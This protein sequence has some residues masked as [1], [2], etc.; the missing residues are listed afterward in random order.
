MTTAHDR[1]TP[2]R[3]V[4]CALSDVHAATRRLLAG[5]RL[6]DLG[7]DARSPRVPTSSPARGVR[8]VFARR[9]LAPGDVARCTRCGSTLGRG[10]WLE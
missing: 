3:P 9:R 4:P 6:A 5:L 8:R 7:S 10:H 2:A 1:P